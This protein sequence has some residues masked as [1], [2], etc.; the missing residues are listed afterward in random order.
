MTT[1][2]G[3]SKLSRP[4]PF[5]PKKTLTGSTSM[6]RITRATVTPAPTLLASTHKKYKA[7]ITSDVKSRLRN[8]PS[9]P[10]TLAPIPSSRPS[11]PTKSDNGRPRTPGTPKRGTT[12]DPSL[13]RATSEM[14]VTNVDPEQ[15]LVD[16]QNVEPEDVSIGELDEAWLKTVQ[17]EHGKEDKVMVSV[18]LRPGG[19]KTAWQPSVST[20]SIHLDPVHAKTPTSFTFDAVLTGS[21][22]KP[23][24][25]T[26]ARSHVVAAMEGFNA[27]VF[28]YGQT[29][30][31]KTYTLSGSESEPG[32]I[33]RAMRQVFSHIRRTETR[34]YLLRCSYLEIYNEQIHDLLAPPG[35]PNKVELQGGS[36][37]GE[38]TLAPLREEVIISIKGVQDVLKRG[39]SHRRTACTDWNER[40]SR[41]HSVF[42]LVIE[43]RERADG[44]APASGRATPSGR[45]TPGH[46]TNHGGPRLQSRDGRSVQTS[47]LSLIDLAG[48]EKATSDKERTREGKYIN[49]SLLTLGSVIG[50]L[51]DNA[52]KQKN[53]H[54]PFRDSKLTRLLQPSL[55]GNARISVICTINPDPSAIA[56][57]TS[58][59]QF[60]KRVKGVKLH[61]Q[62]KQV[63]DTDALIER[64]RK[65][66]ED[67]RSRLEEKENML[68][69][70][71]VDD[72]SKEGDETKVSKL[73]KAKKR[74]MSAQEKADE[75]QAMHDL[76]SRIKQ[77]TKLILTSQTVSEESAGGSGEASRPVSPV[78][79]DFDLSPYELQQQLLT[80]RLQLSSQA[81]QILSLEAALEAAQAIKESSTPAELESANSSSSD[82]SSKESD[83]ERLLQD[84][85]SMIEEQG[86]RIR[87]LE[88]QS[89]SQLSAPG[90]REDLVRQLDDE[91]RKTEEKERWADELVQQLDKERRS[92]IQLE[93]ER[94]ALRAFVSKFDSLGL[95]STIPGSNSNSSTPMGSPVGAGRRRSSATFGIGFP[96]VLSSSEIGAGRRRRSSAFGVASSSLRQPLFPTS[97][98]FSSSSG[99]LS[100]SSST[101]SLTTASSASSLYSI[102]SN[103][104]PQTM[105]KP[106]VLVHRDSRDSLGLGMNLQLSET[107]ES[108]L[109]LPDSYHFSNMPS[110]LEQ[111]PAWAVSSGGGGGGGGVG[112]ISFED[113]EEEVESILGLGSRVPSV[114]GGMK[115][116]TT[117]GVGKGTVRFSPSVDVWGGDGKEN[118]EKEAESI[119]GLGSRVPSVVGGMKSATT[120]GVG[121]G[122]VRFSPSV[123]VRG[124]MGKRM[125]RR[126]KMQKGYDQCFFFLSSNS[127]LQA[128]TAVSSS[129]FFSSAWFTYMHLYMFLLNVVVHHAP[130][131][132]PSFCFRCHLNVAYKPHVAGYVYRIGMVI[133]PWKKETVQKFH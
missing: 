112:D 50:K 49:T 121:K 93:D 129:V 90:E 130:G 10:A 55:S 3:P 53:D 52:T 105:S 62:K 12:P 30:S 117:F 91:K 97:D 46:G 86:R 88:D 72:D 18:R 78:K 102:S 109:R 120:S 83:R 13:V 2:S 32:I 111:K 5:T 8:Q 108:P 74:R 47:V 81:T 63:I 113:D 9:K 103:T 67:L 87:Y 101:T 48:S 71:G 65:E 106:P 131:S 64:Y 127:I 36:V 34:E 28:A 85:A 43:S 26:V 22:N 40:S 119:L 39:E 98:S 126:C 42:R 33:P 14:D 128:R 115:S 54:I 21:A 44:S 99:S 58:T 6:D 122:T 77:L 16:F 110:L 96:S 92:R 124:E 11:S 41:S 132:V 114:V 100:G 75:N 20:N 25:T 84:Q 31:G 17:A 4:V 123:D 89:S 125:S 51:S 133:F 23:I 24:F 68:E 1:N 57:S 76:Q 35:A 59:L 15:V 116:A 61:A 104:S 80:A 118:D 82:E 70:S 79:V 69:N 45:Q 38:I 27:V 95:G 94:R 37:G 56:E 107:N 66:I 29:A 60:A 7:P 19:G 73:V